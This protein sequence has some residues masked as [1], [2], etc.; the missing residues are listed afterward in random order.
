MV[1]PCINL[2]AAA[3]RRYRIAVIRHVLR[4]VKFHIG[5]LSHSRCIA[6]RIVNEQSAAVRYAAG[7]RICLARNCRVVLEYDVF[8]YRTGI[9]FQHD[10]TTDGT[11]S[12]WIIPCWLISG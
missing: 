5:R 12:N 10:G 7:T 9:A 2:S 11:T 6:G 1:A 8:K 4:D 3:V